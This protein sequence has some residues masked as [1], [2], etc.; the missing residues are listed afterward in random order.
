MG[1]T[2]AGVKAGS[3]CG[4][5]MGLL[6][7]MVGLPLI[8]AFSYHELVIPPSESLTVESLA[9]FVFATNTLGATVVGA[10]LGAFYGRMYERL[11][12]STSIRK[13]LPL[14]LA[15]WIAEG[16]IVMIATWHIMPALMQLI[17]V[18]ASLVGS[19]AF[20]GLLGFVYDRLKA[21]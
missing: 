16:P 12:G 1:S 6:G 13:G 3:L 18:S 19:L 21:R 17:R 15:A 9:L 5:V 14:G 11:P 8:L 10:L 20:A 4:A 7:A 2:K